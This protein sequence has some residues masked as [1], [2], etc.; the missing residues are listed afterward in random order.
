MYVARKQKVDKFKCPGVVI[1][2]DGRRNEEI[3]TRIGRTNAVIKP[4]QK[5]LVKMAFYD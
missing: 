1:I 2:S 5:R 4:L 3:D